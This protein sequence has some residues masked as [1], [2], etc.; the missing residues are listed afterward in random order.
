MRAGCLFLFFFFISFFSSAT[1][2]EKK[3]DISPADTIKVAELLT[4]GRKYEQSAP[5][6][7]FSFVSR[8]FVLSKNSGYVLGEARASAQLASI[9]VVYHSLAQATAYAKQALALYKTLGSDYK[10]ELAAAYLN[11]GIYEGKEKM[12]ASA[13][14]DINAA[15]LIYQ[16]KKYQNGIFLC[17]KNLGFIYQLS[18]RPHM[19][20]TF[21]LKAKALSKKTSADT[22]YLTLLEHL[23]NTYAL[24]DSDDRALQVFQEGIDKSSVESSHANH[25]L[26]LL[27]ATGRLH[28][29]LGDEDK[30]ISYHKLALSK[31]T[32]SGKPEEQAR[33]LIALADLFRNKNSAQSI[34]HLNKALGIARQLGN[35]ALAAEIYRSL[36]EIYRQQ[37]R[38]EEALLALSAHHGLLDTLIQINRNNQNEIA[39]SNLTLQ[40]FKIENE[41]LLLENKKRTLE[42]NA[43][44]VVLIVI[45]LLLIFIG[46]HFYLMR[47]LNR[48]LYISNRIKD[49]LF[50]IIGH[51]LRNPIGGIS[52]M[53]GLLEKKDLDPKIL[54]RISGMKNQSDLALEILSAL[55]QWGQAQL[56]G[57]KVKTS[58]FGANGIIRKN[59]DLL[60]HMYIEKEIVVINNVS[61]EVAVSTDADHFDFIIR[62]LL[63]NAIKFSYPAGHL[64]INVKDSD[65]GLLLFSVEDNGIGMSEKQ[66]L[67]FKDGGLESSYGTNGEKGTGIGLMLVKEYVKVNGG[68]IRI[69]SQQGQGTKFYFSLNSA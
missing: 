69:E 13:L 25:H 46:Y 57:I 7:A 17:Y 14:K 32:I 44:G 26:S 38:F 10:L 45:F 49:K 29:K 55:L 6:I 42:R 16:Q 66:L 35:K 30:A 48:K 39:R 60:S 61:D 68:E 53:L 5:S 15:L 41:R 52:T 67:D 40:T 64:V 24:M 21:Y 19:A 37:N 31:S 28:E 56:Q 33:S 9:N 20:L 54:Q 2:K 51:D 65:A 58:S 23:G 18:G 8:A 27:R 47:K 62:N 43:G 4:K 1:K 22:S 36:T 12:Y 63:N 11:L 50:S 34:V 59:L 3:H